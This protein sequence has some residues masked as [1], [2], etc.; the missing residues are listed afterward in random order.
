MHPSA[1]VKS[2]N[3]IKNSKMASLLGK[4]FFMD[5]AA[6]TATV[7]IGAFVIAAE[8]NDECKDCNPSAVV[9]EKTAEAVII[10]KISPFGRLFCP[11]DSRI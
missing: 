11:L 4:P 9:I 8:E 2:A 6:A 3:V 7:V 5:L 10:H 1:V